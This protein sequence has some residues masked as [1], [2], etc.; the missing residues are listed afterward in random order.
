MALG[1]SM[2]SNNGGFGAGSDPA[3]SALVAFMASS[4]GVVRA[5]RAN[6][7]DGLLVL[8]A[9]LEASERLLQSLGASSYFISRLSW[10]VLEAMDDED[11]R[12]SGASVDINYFAEFLRV[13]RTWDA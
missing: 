3:H 6:G 8:L 13:G 1:A 2:T 12:D 7:G 5:L 9:E 4:V 11:H 10:L